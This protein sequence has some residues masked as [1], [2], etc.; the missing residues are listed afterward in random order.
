MRNKRKIFGTILGIVLYVVII[1]AMTYAWYVWRSEY[2][3]VNANIAENS[4][5]VSFSPSTMEVNA[6]DMGPILDY[7][8]S[9]YYTAANRVNIWLL[10]FYC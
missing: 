3:N 6:S 5:G 4:S 10:R 9:E 7:T 2:I 1:V 8:S